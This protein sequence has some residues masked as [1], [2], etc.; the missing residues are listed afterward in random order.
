[1]RAIV[2]VVVKDTLASGSL[3]AIELTVFD[4]SVDV[5]VEDP[6][7]ALGVHLCGSTGLGHAA[8]EDLLVLDG[9]LAVR[10]SRVG[11]FVVGSGGSGSGG[12]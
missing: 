7:L 1:M 11:A 9:S 2:L 10:R 5:V 4:L 8:G 12:K 6:G 3:N